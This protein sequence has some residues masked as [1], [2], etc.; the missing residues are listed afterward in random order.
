MKITRTPSL[1][2]HSDVTDLPEWISGP[3]PWR[4]R[5]RFFQR[6]KSRVVTKLTLSCHRT[7]IIKSFPASLR[8]TFGRRG[9]PG[10]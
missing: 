4:A 8:K 3:R 2:N 7:G 5:D 10:K 6:L 1:A 9:L